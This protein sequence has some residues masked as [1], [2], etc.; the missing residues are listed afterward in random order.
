MFDK[1]YELIFPWQIS[2][3]KLLFYLRTF[4]AED[5]A[6]LNKRPLSNVNYRI[7]KIVKDMIKNNEPF[8]TILVKT[9]IPEAKLREMINDYN[10]SQLSNQDSKPYSDIK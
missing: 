9:K 2:D 1:L 7:N 4:R 5:I 3:D 8:M 6:T 10:F